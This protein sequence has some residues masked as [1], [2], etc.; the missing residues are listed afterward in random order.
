[1]NNRKQHKLSEICNII[2]GGTP[3]TSIAEYWNGEIP[4]LSVVDFNDD[5]R[6]VYTTEKNISELGLQNSSTK[7]L[8][9]GDII[10]SARGTVGALA[11]V[12]RDMTFNQSCY[13]LKAN[14]HSTNDFLYYLVKNSLREL[15]QQVHGSVFDT[16]TRDTFDKISINLPPLA[17]QKSIA[18]ILSSLD[19]KIE[20]NNAINK[21][22]EEQ[23]QAIYENAKLKYFD[24]LQYYIINDVCDVK[25]GKRLSKGDN[26]TTEKT[27]H[28]YIRI[29]DLNNSLILQL[30]NSFEY[31][32]DEIQEK[33]AR[34]IVQTS[35][36]LISIVG[37]IGLVSI[38]HD[39]LDNANL[40][41]NCV[42]LTNLRNIS[43]EYLTLFLR[44]KEGQDAIRKGTVGA[45]QAK[46]PIKNIQA[47]PLALLPQNDMQK[48]NG[49][50]SVI[51]ELISQNLSEMNVLQATRDSLLPK[52]MSG[53]VRVPVEVV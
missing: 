46:L 22:L 5:Y 26:L 37:T 21:N 18:S 45:V 49:E 50:L 6:N 2:G 20:N 32:T 39:T 51:F 35:D 34:Y 12:G 3:K 31:I 4:W 38:V 43:P 19:D 9:K 48:I 13:G 36:V 40:T 25:G 30:T 14:T 47:I 1:M 29:R 41:E 7:Y 44:S 28:P 33:I 27:S 52:L 42:K 10:I 23:A 11:Q 15:K 24:R 16:I 53:E 17:E 8:Q